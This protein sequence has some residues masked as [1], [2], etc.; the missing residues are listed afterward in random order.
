MTVRGPISVHLRAIVSNARTA[1]NFATA[2]GVPDSPRQGASGKP[3]H[4]SVRPLGQ[5]CERAA[6]CD[7]SEISAVIS[8][9]S[10]LS[11][12]R[13]RP[14]GSL[15]DPS[16]IPCKLAVTPFPMPSQCL[17]CFNAQFFGVWFQ[18]MRP[19]LFDYFDTPHQFEGK[20]RP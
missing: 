11:H 3:A 8:T 6:R 10:T 5:S 14:L 15:I 13:E 20:K 9:Q 4:V 19:I 18:N 12:E 17:G 16:V 2:V 7:E 1:G